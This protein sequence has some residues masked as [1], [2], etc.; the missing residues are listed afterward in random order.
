MK[1]LLFIIALLIPATSFAK[2]YIP[3]NQ[4]SDEKFPIAICDLNY[5]DGKNI[6]EV[7]RNDMMLSG[8]FNVFSPESTKEVEKSEGK[9]SDQ[10]NFDKWRQIDALALVK[11]KI[12]KESQ[13][14]LTV[15][16]RLYDSLAGEML[17]GKEYQAG[18][19]QIREVAHRFSDEI[20]LALTGISGVFNTKIA[21]VAPEKK[22]RKEIAV[23]D[24]D[25]YGSWLVTK[26]KSINISPAWS[27][28]GGS[29]AFTSYANGT[30][31]LYLKK[32]GG[33]NMT[34]VTSSEGANLT[35][36]FS[37]TGDKILFASSR[38]SDT[39]LYLASPRG[40]G[41]KQIT[42]SFGID[43]SPSWSP[44][45]Q[46]FVF[47]SDRTGKLHLY[48]MNLSGSFPLRLTFVGYQND[49]PAWSPVGDK[50]AFAG[51]DMGAFD[52]FIMNP[53][54]S[55]IQRLTIGSGNN[56]NPTWSPDG[57]WIAFSSTREG[58]SAIYIMRAD[59]SNQVRV[60]K[61]GGI[62]P[63]WGPKRQ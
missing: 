44:G 35:P 29:L 53:D 32:L 13:G 18:K 8:Y 42:N 1:R 6:A 27:P 41:V 26:N 38:T 34:R 28:D 9:D 23:M 40:K 11:G 19:D 51:R 10:I 62:L 60:S 17:V 47:A 58:G 39:E 45:G 56:E 16:L 37:P 2:I 31:E 7:I 4:P 61:G 15:S 5:S 49:M 22:N 25:G 50:I 46:E 33:N 52:I 55:N 3:V 59:G 14:K 12:V 43:I 36:A 21:Y 57:R 54:G 30:P 20:M 48:S 63:D 24:M